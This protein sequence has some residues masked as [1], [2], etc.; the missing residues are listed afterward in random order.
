MPLARL[1]SNT[2]ITSTN[3]P[4]LLDNSV[5]T[6]RGL[7]GNGASIRESTSAALYSMS[8]TYL[9][10]EYDKYLINFIAQLL[11]YYD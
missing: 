5:N 4:F 6:Y 8:H 10:L 11:K 1:K 3:S 9:Q 2:P 7:E